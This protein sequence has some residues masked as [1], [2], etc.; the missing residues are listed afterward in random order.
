MTDKED[1]RWLAGK[2]TG[3]L[4]YEL[5]EIKIDGGGVEEVRNLFEKFVAYSDQ[6]DK[7]IIKGNLLLLN[8]YNIEHNHTYDE[9][10][11][12]LYEKLGIKSAT[13]LDIKEYN[14]VKHVE[15]EIQNVE[16]D[17]IGVK[18]EYHKD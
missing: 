11:K 18:K 7:E 5:Q 2:K 14:A 16:K 10:I 15:T 9:V 13:K 12:A 6:M 3:L 8:L 1:S 4:D 17:G